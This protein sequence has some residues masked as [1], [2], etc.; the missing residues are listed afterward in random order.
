M[1]NVLY[2]PNVDQLSSTDLKDKGLPTYLNKCISVVY[3]EIIE[4]GE[5]DSEEKNLFNNDNIPYTVVNTS[6]WEVE[7]VK[8]WL[9]EKA[10]THT[11][12]MLT[13]PSFYPDA[14]LDNWVNYS[15]CLTVPVDCLSEFKSLLDSFSKTPFFVQVNA[16]KSSNE[17]YQIL[18]TYDNNYRYFP[19]LNKYHNALFTCQDDA[20]RFMWAV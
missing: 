15:Y 13:K 19:Y 6:F 3:W 7:K 11:N 8:H 10:K 18:E 2:I 1:S 12:L 9:S 14:D 20:D 17:V 5:E 4:C 16:D